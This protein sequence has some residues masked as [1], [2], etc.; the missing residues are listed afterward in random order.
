MLIRYKY[1][2]LLVCYV[3]YG[4]PARLK[5]A[6]VATSAVVVNEHE[7]KAECSRARESSKFRCATISYW[8]VASTAVFPKFSEFIILCCFFRSGH[9]ELSDIE[10]RDLKPEYDFT[11]DD[12][13]WLFSW[14][15]TNP[16]CY[17]PFVTPPTG[18][19]LNQYG[20]LKRM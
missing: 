12:S 7:C 17:T 1:L 20:Y 9:C 2:M 19:F 5:A 8:S 3:A 4:S 10:L 15:F 11:R 16:K 18:S 13:Y 14:D 6:A